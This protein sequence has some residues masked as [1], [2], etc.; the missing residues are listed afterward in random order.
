MNEVD[1]WK[2]AVWL[3]KLLGEDTSS[4][5]DIF[6]LI[7]ANIERSK[8]FTMVFYPMGDRLSGMCV[9]G[10]GSTVIAIN[11]A[12]SVGR[13]HFSM[14]HELFHVYFD[15]NL[16]TAICSQKIGG[17]NEVEREADQFASYFLVPP[18]ALTAAIARVKQKVDDKL[19]VGN[20][21]ELEQYFW[22]SRQAMLFRLLEENELT[23]QE[24]EP[25]RRGVINSARNLGYDDSLYK[26]LPLEKQ[27][28]TYGY[29]I[30]QAE[31]SLKEGLISNGKYEELLLEAF[32][33]D[34][35][36]GEASEGSESV[37]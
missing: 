14:A 26:P 13:Q 11:S 34:L 33:S 31:E 6:P 15:D 29:Y 3:R 7:V 25:M 32:R 16:S 5:I 9:K 19:T 35:V 22:V 4:R 20:V 17:G 30:Q 10:T 2:R 21:V 27:H 28:A 23:S 36:Y 12:M 37:D 1:S 24:A 18:D 8:H